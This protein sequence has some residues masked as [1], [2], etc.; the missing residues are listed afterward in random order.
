[1]AIVKDYIR[2]YLNGNFKKIQSFK[3]YNMTDDGLY[4]ILD[5][6]KDSAYLT[7]DI[8]LKEVI[9]SHFD[10][11]TRHYDIYIK[12]QSTSALS[13]LNNKTP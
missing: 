9:T 4:C 7:N 8:L 3:V 13:R 6:Q 10:Y 5:S 11:N 1:M 12:I 2:D